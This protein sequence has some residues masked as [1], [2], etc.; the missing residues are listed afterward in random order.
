MVYPAL[1]PLMRTPRLSVVNWTDDPA[2]LNELVR[3]AERRNLISAR[4]P[5]HFNWPLT[6]RSCNLTVLWQ[7]WTLKSVKSQNSSFYNS[8]TWIIRVIYTI[9]KWTW[10]LWF[11][12]QTSS[13]IFRIRPLNSCSVETD[14][15]LTSCANISCQALFMPVL[16]AGNF[17][18]VPMTVKWRVILRVWWELRTQ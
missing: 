2:D 16:H 10:S 14:S 4:V 5:S 15:I 13:E 9:L 7:L 18:L 11:L 3:F 12:A 1:L 8:T 6:P 17:L